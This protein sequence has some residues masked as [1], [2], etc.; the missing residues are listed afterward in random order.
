MRRLLIR[1]DSSSTIG[2]GHIS[3]TLSLSERL[4]YNFYITYISIHTTPFAENKII[5]NGYYFIKINSNEE[6]LNLIS[7]DDA[8]LIDNYEIT[9][10]LEKEIAQKA[11]YTITI[12]DYCNRTYFADAVIYHTIGITKDDYLDKVQPS[13]KLYVGLDYCLINQ[14]FVDYKYE[15]KIPEYLSNIF[16]CMGGADP[17]NYTIKRIEEILKIYPDITLHV[18]IGGSYIHKETLKNYDNYINVKIY[19]NLNTVEMLELIVNSDACITSASTISLECLFLRKPLFICQTADNQINYYRGL[20][21]NN[22]AQ[23]VDNIG[24]YQSKDWNKNLEI[25]FPVNRITI[26]KN[27]QSIFEICL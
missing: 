5:E 22:Y 8:V 2:H 10:E 3:R 24:N 9:S 23:V 4:K 19:T 13:T 7:K 21:K 25:S 18:V 26:N 14:V 20:L 16:I 27:L 6:F 1:A 17:E 11:K 12:D 15:L